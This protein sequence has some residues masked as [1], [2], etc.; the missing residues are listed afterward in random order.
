MKKLICLVLALLCLSSIAFAEVVPSKTTSDLVDVEVQVE[1]ETGVAIPDEEPLV[2]QPV[3]IITLKNAVDPVERAA[4]EE[5]LAIV[6]TEVEKLFNTVKDGKTVE[7]YIGTVVDAQ[8]NSVSL[9]AKLGS[10]TLNV[11]EMVPLVVDGYKVE[12]GKVTARM[13]FATLYEKDEPLVVLVGIVN[14]TG[15]EQAVA[16]TAFD[17]IGLGADEGIQVEFDAAI[18]ESIQ[19]ETAILAIASK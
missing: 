17:G 1:T 15:A 6:Q 2:V 19:N 13:S 11:H 8:G 10:D 18:M 9:Q 7:D 5:R 3:T 14:T 4:Y 12:Y 16:W